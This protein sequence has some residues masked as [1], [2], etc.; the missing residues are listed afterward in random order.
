MNGGEEHGNKNANESGSARAFF[1]DTR[2][3][4]NAGRSG[5]NTNVKVKGGERGAARSRNRRCVRI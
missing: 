3:A 5:E 4:A 1:R 2:V